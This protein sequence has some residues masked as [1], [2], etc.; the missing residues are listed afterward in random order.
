MN[1]V[2]SYF[3][4][5]GKSVTFATVDTINKKLIPEVGE[6]LETNNELFKAIYATVSHSKRSIQYAKKFTV[7]S[8]VYKDINTGIG[9]VFEDIKTGNFYN[10]AREQQSYDAAGEAMAGGFDDLDDFGSFDDFDFDFDDDGS[11]DEFS[12]KPAPVGKGDVL[13]AES[14]A[15][16]SNLSSQLISK[17]VAST[18][19][20]IIKAGIAGNNAMMAHNVELVAGLRT[21]I[22][23]VHESING[24][25]KFTS[26]TLTTSINNQAQFFTESLSVL[27]ENNAFLKEIAEIQRNLYNK[28]VEEEKVKNQ[29]ADV[30]GG[31]TL[32]LTEYA[33][34]VFKNV[35]NLDKSGTLSALM[36]DQGGATMLSQF[37]SNPLGGIVTGLVERFIPAA[38]AKSIA[39]FSKSLGNLFP[40]L[41]GKMNKW[42]NEDGIRG[43]LGNLF[44]VSTDT[45]KDI[46]T[47]KYEKGA[48]PFDGITRKAIVDVIPEHLARIESILS[49]SS[50]R[51]YDYYSGKWMTYADIKKNKEDEHRNL[52][53]DSFTD[54]KDDIDRFVKILEKSNKLNAKQKKTLDEDIYNMMEYVYT[55]GGHFSP[56]EVIKEMGHKF[57]NYDAMEALLSAFADN[58][59]YSLSKMTS[60]AGRVFDNKN[61]EA[62]NI[63]E[64][65][66]K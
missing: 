35:K 6:F 2:T 26:E 32:D 30:F 66:A 27:K 14:V 43:I 7:Q 56:K 49:G 52:V 63:R 61:R 17:T 60:V 42:K 10:K 62:Q 54:I 18:S 39:S 47:S 40:A 50:Q 44:G 23:G 59:H 57:K 13:V 21:S 16:S 5:V 19:N 38:T 58:R 24:I 48:V 4:N 9:N 20:N 41:M 8:Q 11:L 37:F 29:Y 64:Y 45:K 1:K 25:L 51:I 53:K 31:G 46:D 36:A 3:K 28:K 15:H 34:A 55:N 65:E 12:D 33:K 22:A